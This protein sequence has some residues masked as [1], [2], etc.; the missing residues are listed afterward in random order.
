MNYVLSTKK[1]MSHI[2]KYLKIRKC[3]FGIIL[4]SFHTYSFIKSIN[5]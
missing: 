1:I 5:N 4:S 2:F 3:T